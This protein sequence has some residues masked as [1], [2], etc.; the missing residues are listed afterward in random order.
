VKAPKPTIPRCAPKGTIWYGG[1]IEWF[2]LR[3]AVTSKYL[4]PSEVTR[5]IGREPDDAWER[6]KPLLW[7]DGSIKR[8]PKFGLWSIEL[9][10]KDTDEWDCGAAMMELLQRLP[11]NISLWKNLAARHKVNVTFALLMTSTN[12]GFE[13]S[14]EVLKFLGDRGVKAAFDIYYEADERAEPTAPPNRR[15]A[16]QRAVRTVRKGGGR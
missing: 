9:K 13:L 14:P 5:L 15:P 16:R 6:G 2:V 1:P 8:I 12:K 4:V 10:P 3:I 11:S 7:P